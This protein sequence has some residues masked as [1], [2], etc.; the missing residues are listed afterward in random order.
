MLAQIA[1]AADPAIAAH[2]VADP[3][4]GRFEERL[5]HNRQRFLQFPGISQQLSGVHMQ[6]P[7]LETYPSHSEFIRRV[8]RILG[9]GL[10]VIS[11]RGIEILARFGGL[12]QLHQLV[13]LAIPR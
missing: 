5:D 6:S 11:Q 10:V 9:H 7:G 1:A 13:T 2:A 8:G 3:P 4:T 12:G